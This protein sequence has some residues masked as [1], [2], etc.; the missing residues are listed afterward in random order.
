[1][2]TVQH[3]MLIRGRVVTS[4]YDDRS[5]LSILGHGMAILQ[6]LCMALP[7]MCHLS[8][9]MQLHVLSREIACMPY[10]HAFNA[11]S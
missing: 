5:R 2:H 3:H 9:S 4:D 10:Q 11:H 6:T 1:M 7:L 8:R